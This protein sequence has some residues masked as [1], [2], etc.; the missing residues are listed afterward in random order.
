MEKKYFAIRYG[1]KLGVIYDTWD[2]VKQYVENYPNSKFKSF[3][4]KEDAEEFMVS[5]KDIKFATNDT[6]DNKISKLAPDEVMAFVDGSYK[7]KMEGC[8]KGKIGYGVVLITKSEKKK[9]SGSCCNEEMLN[10]HNIAGELLGTKR[11]VR[12]VAERSQFHTLDLYFDFNGIAYFSKNWGKPNKFIDEYIDFID[13]QTININYY[14][15]KAHTGI[16]Y[17]EEADKLAKESLTKEPS[18]E[19]CK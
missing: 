8:S 5:G 17:N 6:I 1:R 18:E 3:E 12:W 15:V 19:D 2:N 11:A 4:N 13:K 9:L 7:D 10:L 16:E 14:K